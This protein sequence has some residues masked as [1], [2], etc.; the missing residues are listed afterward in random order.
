MHT[1]FCRESNH[2]KEREL[3]ENVSVEQIAKQNSSP[4]HFLLAHEDPNIAISNRCEARTWSKLART[5]H[6]THRHD[7]NWTHPEAEN[8]Q[9]PQPVVRS[10]NQW[11]LDLNKRELGVRSKP[12]NLNVYTHVHQKN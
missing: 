5:T 8:D 12:K 9:R 4:L 2:D 6:H 11:S 3:I 10:R 7:A 1:W